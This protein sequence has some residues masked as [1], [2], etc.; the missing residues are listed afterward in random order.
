VIIGILSVGFGQELRMSKCISIPTDK[1]EAFCKQNHIHSFGLF[2]SALW[3]DFGPGSDIDVLIEFEQQHEPD[4][5]KLV[6]LQDELS[7]MLGHMVDL[8]ER[9][10]VEKSENYIRRHHILESME[11]IYVAR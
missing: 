9:H 6:D 5:F 10:A 3:E 11:P 2:G 1:I 7:K 4:L 8:V